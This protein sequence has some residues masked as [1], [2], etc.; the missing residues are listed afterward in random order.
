LGDS[1]EAAGPFLI[2]GYLRE[3]VQ[4]SKAAGRGVIKIPP[5]K[6]NPISISWSIK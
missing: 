6:F 1:G 5:K 3:D 4:N 2:T